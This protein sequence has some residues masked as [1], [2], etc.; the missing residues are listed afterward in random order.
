MRGWSSIWDLILLLLRFEQLLVTMSGS[1][2]SD[3]ETLWVS[4][5]YMEGE[6]CPPGEENLPRTRSLPS[7]SSAPVSVSS[8]PPTF[9]VNTYTR[10]VATTRVSATI[11]SSPSGVR[12]IRTRVVPPASDEGVTIQPV[13]FFFY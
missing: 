5:R 8:M 10:P 11:T 13:S 12:T 6:L 7:R 3:Y 2:E 4:E 1:E 9:S